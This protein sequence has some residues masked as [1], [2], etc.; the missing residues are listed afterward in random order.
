MSLASPWAQNPFHSQFPQSQTGGGGGAPPHGGAEPAPRRRTPV[1][2]RREQMVGGAAEVAVPA[3]VPSRRER[4]PE[5]P[6]EVPRRPTRFAEAAPEI[7]TEI[8]VRTARVQIR[9]E[10]A[11]EMGGRPSPRRGRR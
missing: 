8:G 7:P 1:P 3:Q 10:V 2:R 5:I 6:A 4:S 9:Q 11:A